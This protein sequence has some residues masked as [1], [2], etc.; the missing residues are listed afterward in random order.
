MFKTPF[1]TILSKEEQADATVFELQLNPDCEVY[2]GH[3]P[4]KAVAPGV[5]NIGMIRSCAE[6]MAG[7][8]LFLN[9]ISQCKFT[10]LVTPGECPRLS[11][12]AQLTPIEPGQSWKLRATLYHEDKTYLELKAEVMTA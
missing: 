12:R 1:F 11:L 7:R 9:A 5:C 10:A 8:K 6:E 4:E 3:F 2:Q